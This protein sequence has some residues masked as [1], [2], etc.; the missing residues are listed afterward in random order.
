MDVYINLCFLLP[1]PL[2]PSTKALKPT[3]VHF[4]PEEETLAEDIFWFMDCSISLCFFIDLVMNLFAN[5]AN[6]FRL[7]LKYYYY[8]LTTFLMNEYE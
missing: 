5:S 2:L 6:Y 1:K 8:Y 7:L 4:L 3:Q